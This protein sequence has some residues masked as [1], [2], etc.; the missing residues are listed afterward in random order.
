MKRIRELLEVSDAAGGRRCFL[1]KDKDKVGNLI[2]DHILEVYWNHPERFGIQVDVVH[3]LIHAI[4][5][6]KIEDV[7]QLNVSQ[8]LDYAQSAFE[9]GEWSG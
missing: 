1:N 8:L 7:R 3:R 9:S 2:A 5:Q 6:A 4:F